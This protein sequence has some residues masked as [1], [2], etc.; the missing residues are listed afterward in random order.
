MS[1]PIPS[2]AG[3]IA[4]AGVVPPVNPIVKV[5]EDAALALKAELTSPAV[6]KTI[7][8]GVFG[9]LSVEFPPAAPFLGLAEAFVLKLI[10]VQS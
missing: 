10:P 7:I 4:A 2:A 1:D 3:V 9:F 5:L 6:E 8:T